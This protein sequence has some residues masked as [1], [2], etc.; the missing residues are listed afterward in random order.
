[1][2]DLP[3]NP[4]VLVLPVTG[5]SS[6][7]HSHPQDTER[8]RKKIAKKGFNEK[9]GQTAMTR[10][11][12]GS[13]E[14]PDQLRFTH[15]QSLLYPFLPDP[16]QLLAC[17]FPPCVPSPLHSHTGPCEHPAPAAAYVQPRVRTILQAQN[18]HVGGGELLKHVSS[19]RSTVA[20]GEPQER[21]RRSG[22]GR[23][24]GSAGTTW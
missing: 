13:D 8:S 16:P 5:T 3:P 15:D 4:L 11:R 6:L 12:A 18:I 19:S 21:E 2:Q 24:D 1:M 9:V 23:R 14:R 7:Q 10:H 20:A 22:R 17:P